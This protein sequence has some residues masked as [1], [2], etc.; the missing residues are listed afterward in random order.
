LP[1]GSVIGSGGK[2]PLAISPSVSPVLELA[3]SLAVTS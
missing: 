1:S 2:T 3:P